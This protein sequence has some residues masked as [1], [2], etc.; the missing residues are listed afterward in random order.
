M[1]RPQD[2]IMPARKDT[3]A[4]SGLKGIEACLL[5]SFST[6]QLGGSSL[7]IPNQQLVG[8]DTDLDR[9]ADGV[10]LVN[11]CVQ[12][13]FAQCGHRYRLAR[14][15]ASRTYDKRMTIAGIGAI[16]GPRYKFVSPA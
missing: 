11:H 5:S 8:V 1:P 6:V 13:R 9:C 16:L 10:D 2:S 4:T 14:R 3:L 12:N 15:N 7:G